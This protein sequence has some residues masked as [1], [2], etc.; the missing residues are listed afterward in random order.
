[1][2]NK[3]HAIYG[4][5]HRDQ[6]NKEEYDDENSLRRS[7]LIMFRQECLW[8]PSEYPPASA[9]VVRAMSPAVQPLNINRDHAA[10]VVVA[11]KS[12]NSAA[13]ENSGIKPSTSVG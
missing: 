12:C 1:M 2:K 6:L 10:E 7:F 8:G 4:D 3:L 5:L 11:A 9:N 13:D